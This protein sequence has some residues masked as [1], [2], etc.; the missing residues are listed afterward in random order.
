MRQDLNK[1]CRE[2]AEEHYDEVGEN[3]HFQL[4]QHH[5]ANNGWV[6]DVPYSFGMGYFYKDGDD[7]V[8]TEL[9][10]GAPVEVRTA[11]TGADALLVAQHG[12]R[13]RAGQ[14]I[15]RELGRRAHVDHRVERQRQ[16]F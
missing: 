9:G 12:Q 5:E 6:I 13:N 15:L 16:R 4:E 14:V 1:T 7:V 11:Q 3:F 10:N 8:V 2:L